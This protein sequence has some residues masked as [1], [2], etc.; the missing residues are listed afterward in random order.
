MKKLLTISAIALTSMFA[1]TSAHAN[2]HDADIILNQAVVNQSAHTVVT[3][4]KVKRITV[5]SEVKPSLASTNSEAMP[6]K[7]NE[8]TLRAKK[9]VLKD[10]SLSVPIRNF[11]VN[12]A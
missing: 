3:K 4:R 1:T 9:I 7:F 10:I 5:V 2:Q 8:Q 12:G 6:N 11:H